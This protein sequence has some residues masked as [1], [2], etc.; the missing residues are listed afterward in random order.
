MITLPWIDFTGIVCSVAAIELVVLL[1]VF[2]GSEE[3]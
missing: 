3:D 1:W 2:S